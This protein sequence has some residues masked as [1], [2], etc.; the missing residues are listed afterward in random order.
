MNH[1]GL[2]KLAREKALDQARAGYPPGPRRL[3]YYELQVTKLYLE[4]ISPISF[5]EVLRAPDDLM[6]ERSAQSSG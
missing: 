1:D 4:R 6:Q 3:Q 2:L 5:A